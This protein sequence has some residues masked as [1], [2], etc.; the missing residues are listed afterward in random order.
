MIVTLSKLTVFSIEYAYADEMIDLGI[1]TLSIFDGHPNIEL[2]F[3]MMIIPFLLNSLQYW[4]Q[5]SFLAGT[6]FIQKQKENA[7]EDKNE[8]KEIYMDQ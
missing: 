7:A 5:D 4:I 8:M 1:T 2:I 6:E 3:V